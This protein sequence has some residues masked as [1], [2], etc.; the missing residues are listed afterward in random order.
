MELASADAKRSLTGRLPNCPDTLVTTM[1]GFLS[2]VLL[3]ALE[4]SRASSQGM[5]HTNPGVSCLLL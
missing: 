4:V 1:D 2:I 5:N 3:F